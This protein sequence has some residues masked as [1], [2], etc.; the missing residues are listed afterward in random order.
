[1]YIPYHRQSLFELNQTFTMNVETIYDDDRE[2]DIIVI[3]DLFHNIE[4][5]SSVFINSPSEFFKADDRNG[6]DYYD[7]R[8]A[9]DGSKTMFL[10]FISKA[11]HAHYGVTTASNCDAEIVS[12][13]FLSKSP[14]P[15]DYAVPHVDVS[16]LN[17]RRRQ[18][19]ILTYLNKNEDCVGGTSFFKNTL[20]NTCLPYNNDTTFWR[21]HDEGI[22]QSSGFW[23]KP[24]HRA[25]WE[26][27]KTVD[28]KLNRTIIFPAD[29][30]HSAFIPTDI[31]ATRPRVTMVTW[32]EEC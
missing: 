27:R 10:S 5:L 16:P 29:V 2:F 28:M 17:F 22:F 24:E 19:S 9:I 6:I 31:Y 20:L 8:R 4:L 1:M 15:T 21:L 32:M 14:R 25:A 12:N 13:W 18:F 26:V 30:F 11:I 3:D 23:M 7:C